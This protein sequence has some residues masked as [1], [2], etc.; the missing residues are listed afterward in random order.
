MMSVYDEMARIEAARHKAN[1]RLPRRQRI[2]AE[3]DQWEYTV[4]EAA[5]VLGEHPKTVYRR[6]RDGEIKASRRSPRKTRIYY[7]DLAAYIAKES[8]KKSG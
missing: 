3:L 7:T 5:E 4:P 8:G 1:S 6:I 2:E